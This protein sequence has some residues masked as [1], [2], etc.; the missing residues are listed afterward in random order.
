[1]TFTFIIN[2]TTERSGIR[3]EG[4]FVARATEPREVPRS[5]SPRCGYTAVVI[6][7]LVACTV[8]RG[9]YPESWTI[10]FRPQLG[11]NIV[12]EPQRFEV[13]EGVESFNLVCGDDDDVHQY[14][15]FSLSG[16]NGVIA[17][18]SRLIPDNPHYLLLVPGPLL[19]EQFPQ[20]PNEP[21]EPGIFTFRVQVEPEEAETE[22]SVV[23][24]SREANRVNLGIY[25]GSGTG[26]TAEDAGADPAVLGVI[27]EA[28]DAYS[29]FGL[30]LGD[31]TWSDLPTDSYSEPLA[32]TAVVGEGARLCRGLD[33]EPGAIAVVLVDDIQGDPG[34]DSF[35]AGGVSPAP[36][37]AG[38]PGTSES[39]IAIALSAP[40]PAHSLAHELGHFLGLLHPVEWN[41]EGGDPLDDTPMC[42][43]DAD[44]DGNGALSSAECGV[45]GDLMWWV[46]DTDSEALTADQLW[47]L[48]RSPGLR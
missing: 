28:F 33:V 25:V 10:R 7:W 18:Y 21:V 34:P 8:Q 15:L 35:S 13:P 19:V 48:Q 12:S 17:G 46:N 5:D 43:L 9:E 39:C 42:T 32:A 30:E 20:A 37:A 45:D 41:G 44:T 40:D 1:M 23:W 47:V 26:M 24:G 2:N 4:F 22:C 11:G 27:E 16:P 3:E 29:R 36:G 31:V 38:R 14:S 6:F